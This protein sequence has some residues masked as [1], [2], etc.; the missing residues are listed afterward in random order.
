MIETYPM[1]VDNSEEHGEKRTGTTLQLTPTHQ[2]KL[3]EL[4]ARLG[5]KKRRVTEN[6]VEWFLAQPEE[7]QWAIASDMPESIAGGVARAILERMANAP[8]AHTS[9]HPFPDKKAAMTEP[10]RKRGKDEGA[11]A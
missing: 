7:I 3:D 2:Q 4:V 5:M 1:A 6:L 11:G 8:A 9:A 10:K